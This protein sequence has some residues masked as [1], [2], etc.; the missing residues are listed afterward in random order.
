M[1]RNIL[2]YHLASLCI[3]NCFGFQR[4]DLQELPGNSQWIFFTGAEQSTAILKS[5]ALAHYDQQLRG[6]TMASPPP[7]GR[8]KLEI[9]QVDRI[10]P[11]LEYIYDGSRIPVSNAYPR[12][13]QAPYLLGYGSARHNHIHLNGQGFQRTTPLSAVRSLLSEVAPKLDLPSELMLSYREKS[14]RFDALVTLMMAVWPELTEINISR[15]TLR[16]VL[17]NG[18]IISWRDL[19]L[20]RAGLLTMVADIYLRLNE[21][22]GR[23]LNP[24]EVTGMVLIEEPELNLPPALRWKLATVLSSIFPRVQF[25]ATTYSPLIL[26]GAPTNSTFIKVEKDAAGVLQMKQTE[27][28]PNQLSPS[29]ILASPLF[30]LK[31]MP[32]TKEPGR[33]TVDDFDMNKAIGEELERRPS[34]N[35]EVRLFGGH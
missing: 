1:T 14:G 24:E 19:S 5:I 18:E 6:L 7:P 3:E 33:A 27:M 23:N 32:V 30:D 11:H 34:G 21:I 20:G 17:N 31:E 35:S 2:P 29:E 9:M 15:R 16:F 26:M 10:L 25:V 13:V 12:P 8:V 22:Q 4:S 28:T